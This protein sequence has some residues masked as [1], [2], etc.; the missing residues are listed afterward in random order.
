[1][2]NLENLVVLR[3]SRN[4]I[5]N[6]TMFTNEELFHK[7]RIL[8]IDTNK[9]IDLPAIKLPK[10]ELL[11]ISDNRIE[12]FDNWVGHPTIRV[13]KSVDNKFKNLSVLKEMPKLE[14]VYLGSN[15]IAS[16]SGWENIPNIKKL[17]LRKCKIEKIDDELPELANL[18]YLN[19]RGNKI[20]NFK[21]ITK[22]F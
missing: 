19:L 12:K 7:L 10:L 4:K 5:K 17:H 8:E 3:L 14:E 1:M 6:I 13:F 16:L 21:M 20:G 11:N 15:P 22:M 9:Y 18:T 2:Q